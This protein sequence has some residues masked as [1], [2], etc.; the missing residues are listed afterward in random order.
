MTFPTYPTTEEM[1]I[2]KSP[3]KQFEVRA[4][5]RLD[6]P[7]FIS[8]FEDQFAG[9]SVDRTL[10]DLKKPTWGVA[11]VSGGVLTLGANGDAI[12]P[13]WVVSKPNLAFPKNTTTSW[14][15]ETR[16]R[17][18]TITGFGMFF[19]VGS[20]EYKE[21]VFA[22]KCNEN[23]LQ[24]KLPDSSSYVEGETD[25]EV[26]R[27]SGSKTDWRR[28][29]LVYN[30]RARTYTVYI[31]EDDDGVFET[32]PF[33]TSA[34]GKRADFIVIG[35]S[36]AR[37]G[38]LGAWTRLQVSYVTVTGVSES[39]ELPDWAGPLYLYDA[40]GYENELWSTLPTVLRGN[41]DIGLKNMTDGLTLDLLNFSHGYDRTDPQWQVYKDF[42]FLNRPVK[43]L[44]RVNNGYKW[45]PWRQIYLGSCD[46]KNIELRS[47]GDCVLTVNARDIYR[48]H[49]EQVHTVR[50]YAKYDDDIEGLV[51]NK[52]VSEIIYDIAQEV[53]GLPYSAVDCIC[54]PHNMPQTFNIARESCSEAVSRLMDETCL[55]WMVDHSNGQVLIR[56]Y[57]WGT[58]TP[59]YHLSTSEEVEQVQ[60]GENASN[61]ASVIELGIE[62]TEFED[63]GFSTNS[64][65][66]PVPF[67]G[68]G[69]Y[70]STLVA[71]NT[72]SLYGRPIY[73]MMW[74][75]AN[76]DV[77]SLRLT[78]QCQDWLQIGQEISVR[79]D[80]YLGI[81]E[82]DGPWVVDAVSF[83]WEGTN[84]YETTVELINQH[85]DRIIR[86]SLQ[87]MV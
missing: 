87:G 74:K 34:V 44:S 9:S 24:V 39:L 38:W 67:Y 23:Y 55:C 14:T 18:P 48:K 26:W 70:R 51:R 43:I 37:Q 5:V 72:G 50:A 21:A 45:T 65:L 79:D 63:G 52:V 68:H 33:S 46:E 78:M 25:G 16:V 69:E 3:I 82:S 22:I 59:G 75:I 19:R 66:A 42:S 60:W 11:T 61:M 30:A 41:V 62:N 17:F 77:G 49:L 85:P 15:L 76:R 64:P 83:D 56:D 53:C 54:T 2:Y 31:D 81:K 32:G 6:Q 7:I 1:E 84:K 40:I 29:K 28:Y 86:K 35:N 27:A 47:N 36:T 71:Q 73:Y 80:K 58:D 12:S 57:I 8:P 4:A 13:A 20:L 10:W